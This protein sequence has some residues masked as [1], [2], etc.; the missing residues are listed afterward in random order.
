MDRLARQVNVLAAQVR[1][2]RSVIVTIPFIFEKGTG[3]PARYIRHRVRFGPEMKQRQ[4]MTASKL[5]ITANKTGN[6]N[7]QL[8]ILA[9]FEWESVTKDISRKVR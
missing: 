5:I 7:G 6:I 2:Q 8:S 3:Q 1:H 9:I 4:L